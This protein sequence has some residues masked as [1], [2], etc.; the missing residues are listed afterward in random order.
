MESDISAPTRLAWVVFAQGPS[1]KS[2]AIKI[3]DHE[4][5]DRTVL[6]N[7]KLFRKSGPVVLP[8][9]A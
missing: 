2:E 9:W 5:A 4:D 6:E 1:G 8:A 7:P 3:T